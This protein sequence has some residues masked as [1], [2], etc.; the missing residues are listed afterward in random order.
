MRLTTEN[1]LI[2]FYDKFN[3]LY[4]FCGVRYFKDNIIEDF[5]TPILYSDSIQVT[6][7]VIEKLN[8]ELRA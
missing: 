4:R 3:R 5:A 7:A 8:K 1:P 6:R 2:V